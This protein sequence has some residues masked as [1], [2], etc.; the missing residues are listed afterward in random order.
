MSE[1]K[2][3]GWLSTLLGAALPAVVLL[4]GV[5][6]FWTLA[7][8]K[9]APAR[10]ES[11]VADPLVETLEVEAAP[12][13][14]AIKLHGNVVPKRIVTL[15]AEVPGRVIH[16]SDECDVG[17]FITKGT[18]LLKIDPRPYEL[19]IRRLRAELSQARVN[20]TRL[21]VEEAN[22]KAMLEI[23]EGDREIAARER[24]RL[25][26]LF[27]RKAASESER[28]QSV[29]SFFKARNSV[30]SLTNELRLVDAR[31]EGLDAQIELIEARLELARIDLEHTT[32]HAP[33]DGVITEES[34]EENGFVQPGTKLAMIRDT[35]AVE[36]ECQ[37]RPEDLTWIWGSVDPGPDGQIEV[38]Q[39]HEAPPISA[40]VSYRVGSRTYT[41]NGEL[42]KFLG[43]GFD[44]KTRTIPCLVEVAQPRSE[45]SAGGPPMLIPGMFVSVEL[46]VIPSTP[47]VRIPYVALKP[48]NVV[49]LVD[50]GALRVVQA[51]VARIFED[52]VFVRASDDGLQVGDRVVVSPL[53]VASDGIK[54][55][56]QHR[57]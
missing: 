51:S 57:R 39:L 43:A 54:V 34:V 40:T 50:D 11:V 55:R 56:E 15:G 45:T 25:E 38:D 4:A 1:R 24:E 16:K 53:A 28:D 42:G 46:H 19:E 26:L 29:S 20:R 23:S 6:G 22:A 37:L 21:D 32:I 3:T 35:S 5:A 18:L 52:H 14:F 10:E 2:P 44:Q 17:N 31:R 7:S 33:I 41:W 30:Q 8:L 48:G 13:S 36:I 9:A 12:S 27:K 47:L 49:W